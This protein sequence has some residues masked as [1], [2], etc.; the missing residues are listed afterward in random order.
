MSFR[1][2]YKYSLDAKGRLSFPAKYRDEIAGKYDSELV[3]TTALDHCLDCFPL[4]EWVK[5][6]EKIN[7]LPSSNRKIKKFKR[8]YISGAEE[9]ALDK[10]GRILLSPTLRAWAGLEGSNKAVVLAGQISRVEIWSAEIWTAE[11]W[12]PEHWSPEGREEIVN[13]FE[14]IED[15]LEKFGF[16]L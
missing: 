14:S 11:H 15:E 1:G 4:A 7:A 8:F 10:Q 3:I 12:G 2:R 5:V 6:E 13:E 9:I 16:S